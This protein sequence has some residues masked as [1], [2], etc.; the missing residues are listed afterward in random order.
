MYPTY[1][2]FF[3]REKQLVWTWPGLGVCVYLF[4]CR[5]S[6]LRQRRVVLQRDS[7]EVGMEEEEDRL[8]VE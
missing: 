5:D 2:E 3:R 1:Q 4:D 7:G 8:K 6:Q